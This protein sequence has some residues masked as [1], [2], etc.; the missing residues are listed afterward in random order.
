M[1]VCEAPYCSQILH[2]W[3]LPA[4]AITFAPR[5][6][7]ISTAAK[8]TPPAAPR[9]RQVWFF[10]SFPFQKIAPWAVP[11]A[12]GNDDAVSVG[13]DNIRNMLAI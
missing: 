1:I 12:T 5:L 7:A 3:S 9:I 13:D 8:P 4:A 11:Y 6:L 10:L 2:F